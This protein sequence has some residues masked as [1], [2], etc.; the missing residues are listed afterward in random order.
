MSFNL[1]KGQS[2]KLSKE[3]LAFLVGLGWDAGDNFDLD[4]HAF[5]LGDDQKLVDGN[6]AVGYFAASGAGQPATT[7]DGG[8]HYSGDNLTGEGDG[9]DET[10]IIK[11]G[12]VDP[13]VKEIAVWVMIYDAKNRGQHF[14][15]VKNAFARVVDESTGKEEAKF[16]LGNEFIGDTALHVASLLRQADNSWKFAA[17]GLGVQEEL[18]AVLKGYGANA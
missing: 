14:G 12:S 3:A 2:M 17:V 7:A 1:Q 8:L 4:A 18:P 15:V 11:Q 6:Y 10:I 16:D 13:R 9:D 5:G